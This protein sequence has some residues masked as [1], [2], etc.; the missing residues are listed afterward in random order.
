MATLQ[1]SIVLDIIELAEL[2]TAERDDY[3]ARWQ[4]SFA[5]ASG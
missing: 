1:E 5:R 2:I 3:Y 4:L